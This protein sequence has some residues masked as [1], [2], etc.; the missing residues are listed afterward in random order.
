MRSPSPVPT[1]VELRSFL[2]LGVS[3]L[4]ATRDAGFA[5]AI[6]RCGGA[7]LGDD[8]LVR[9]AV[10]APE[11][12]VT[13]ANIE[14]T[15]V[16]ALTAARPTT[17]RTLQVKGRDAKRI[18]WP[19]LDDVVT[20]HRAAVVEEVTSVGLEGGIGEMFWS[21]RFVAIAFSPTEIFDQTPGPSAG[22]A[23]LA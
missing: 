17:Y 19:E 23:L 4:V 9:I 12:N 11:G 7:R 6:C 20:A 10:A 15:G 2:Q 5:P 1:L 14:S 22:V 18:E 3:L 13:V 16:V 8:G 21:P